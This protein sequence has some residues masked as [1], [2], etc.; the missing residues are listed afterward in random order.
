MTLGMLRDPY[1][2]PVYKQ[3]EACQSQHGRAQ[4]PCLLRE[5]TLLEVIFWMATV[6]NLVLMCD[7]PNL[8]LMCDDQRWQTYES[9]FDPIHNRAGIPIRLSGMHSTKHS[10]AVEGAPLKELLGEHLKQLGNSW[11]F[12]VFSIVAASPI[13]L[14]FFLV[15]L[16]KLFYYGCYGNYMPHT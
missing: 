11:G 2:T 4:W 5:E 15:N 9:L 8:V 16:F 12:L 14:I 3:P 7:G 10:V 6:S 1:S 13:H